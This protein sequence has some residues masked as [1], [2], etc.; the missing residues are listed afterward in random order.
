MP[1]PIFRGLEVGSDLGTAFAADAA[2]QLRPDIGQSDVIRP[3]VGVYHSAMTAMVI[4]AIHQHLADALVAHLAEGDYGDGRHLLP[5][6]CVI[7]LLAFASSSIGLRQRFRELRS[8]DI[9]HRFGSRS[10]FM[11]NS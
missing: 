9:A 4:A 3:A 7:M 8:A 6:R 11:V 10:R 2:S 1:V 5:L